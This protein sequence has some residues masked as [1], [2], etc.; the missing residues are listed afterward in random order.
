MDG[1]PEELTRSEEK[2]SDRIL[3]GE[4]EPVF[5]ELRAGFEPEFVP[6]LERLEL[7]A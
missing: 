6:D 4:E 3:R 7:G 1:D 2:L 5:W